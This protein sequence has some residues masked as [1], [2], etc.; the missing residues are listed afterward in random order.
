MRAPVSLG[1]KTYSLKIVNH[2]NL[3]TVG[4]HFPGCVGRGSA[5]P[6]GILI[7]PLLYGDTLNGLFLH[8]AI[9]QNVV[10]GRDAVAVISHGSGVR[11]LRAA[12]LRKGGKLLWL[13]LV[14]ASK[15]AVV[16]QSQPRQSMST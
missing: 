1:K 16:V 10:D 14:R 6:F 8:W 15:A 11:E 3:D 13:Y 9:L 7:I 5:W 4:R 12:T 2:D